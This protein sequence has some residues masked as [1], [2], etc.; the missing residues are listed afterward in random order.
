MNIWKRGVCLLLTLVLAAALA[1]L[2]VAAIS[3]IQRLLLGRMG[4][5]R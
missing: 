5:A 4:M 1:G 2:L 3:G